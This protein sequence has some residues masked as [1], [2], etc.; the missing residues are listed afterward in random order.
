[1]KKDYFF[2]PVRVIFFAGLIG[3]GWFV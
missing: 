2:A 1:M 3:L